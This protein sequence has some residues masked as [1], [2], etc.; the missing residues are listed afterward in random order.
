MDTPKEIVLR[1]ALEDIKRLGG[2]CSTFEICTHR[3]CQDSY[4]AWAIADRALEMCYEPDDTY[5]YQVDWEH[6]LLKPLKL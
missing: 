6:G 2:V 4:S 1:G 5:R 3:A